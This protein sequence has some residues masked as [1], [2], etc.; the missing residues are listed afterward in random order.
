MLG[1]DWL[2]ILS[3]LS[4]LSSF[5]I[6]A[7]IF[8]MKNKVQI[9]YAFLCTVIL[10][11]YWSIIRFVQLIIEDIDLI[12]FL[13]RIHYI[14]VSLLPVAVLF[15]GIIFAKNRITFSRKYILLF[16]I[17]IISI[18]LVLTNDYHHLFIVEYSLIS[19]EFVYG[20]YYIVHELYSYISI[21]IG[22]YYLFYFSIKNSGFFSGQSILIFLGVAFPLSIIILSTQKIVAMPVAFENISFS[23]SMLFFSFAIFK[24]KF[25]NIVPIALQRIVD[26][27]SDS[28][29]VVNEAGEIIDYNK[30]FVNTFQGIMRIQRKDNIIDILSNLELQTDKEKIIRLIKEALEKKNN[31]SFEEHLIGEDFDKYFI[32]EITPILSND[33]LLGT[34]ILFKDVSEHKKNIEIIKR[35]QEILMEQERMVSLGQMIGGIAHNLNTPI[36]SLAGGIEALKDLTHEY[37]D[38]IED[39]NVTVEDHKEIADEI[40]EWLGKMKP[41]CSYMTDLIGAV[42]GQ[43]VQMNYSKYDKFTIEELVKRIDV[44]MKHELKRYHCLLK[45]DFNIDMNTEIK[46][47]L[48]GLVQVFDNMILNAIHAYEGESGEIYFKIIKIGNDVEFALRDNGKGM[49]EEVQKKLFKEML[50]TKGKHGTGLGLYMSYSTIRGRFLGNMRFESTEGIGTTF[51]ITIPCINSEMQQ[52]ELR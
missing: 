33:S 5:F 6:T 8:R 32:I 10:V 1:F 45:T 42:K 25:L 2:A 17:P 46:G 40:L 23:I 44:L 18:I 28:Y 12:L 26:L 21:F 27:I 3:S 31:T 36:M 22:L 52:E 48:N 14:G 29:I 15:T 39:E 9:H 16:I 11:L 43:A 49:P 51:Y 4:I 34:I 30:P 37:K 35:N 38:S 7:L 41:Y 19:T 47:E 13:E 50:T 24:F 20:P